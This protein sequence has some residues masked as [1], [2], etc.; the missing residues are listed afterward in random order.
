MVRILCVL[1]DRVQNVCLQVCVLC[2]VV[3]CCDVM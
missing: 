2:C 1:S 3:L